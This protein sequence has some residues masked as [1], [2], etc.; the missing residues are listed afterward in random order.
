MFK[1]RFNPRRFALGLL[2][3]YLSYVGMFWLLQ[4]QFL[5]PGQHRRPP[6]RAAGDNDGHHGPRRTIYVLDETTDPDL[7][8][9]SINR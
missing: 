5:Y 3:V 2:F 4:R 9:F 6:E 8:D 7:R 1:Q